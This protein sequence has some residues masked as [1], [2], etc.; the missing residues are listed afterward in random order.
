[1]I[2]LLADELVYWHWHSPFPMLS[3]QG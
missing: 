1:M 2:A 3:F